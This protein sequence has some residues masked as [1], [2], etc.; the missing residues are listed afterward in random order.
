MK[1]FVLALCLVA[2]IAPAYAGQYA[3]QLSQCFAGATTGKDR[4][5]L[6]RWVFTAMSTHPALKDMTTITPSARDASDKMLANLFN[7]LM[8]QDCAKEARDVMQNEG[9]AGMRAGWETLGRLAMQELMTDP[10]VARS[11]SSFEKYI[12]KDKLGATL[13]K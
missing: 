7:R 6:A 13:K 8:T 9:Q 11:F 5:D 12:D 1:K 4:T 3:D 10:A 2:G